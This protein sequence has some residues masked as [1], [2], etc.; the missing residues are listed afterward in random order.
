[1]LQVLSWIWSNTVIAGKDRSGYKRFS[2]SDPASFGLPDSPYL[3]MQPV[4]RVGNAYVLRYIDPMTMEKGTQMFYDG[5]S[6][7][8]FMSAGSPYDGEL[9]GADLQEEQQEAQKIERKKRSQE[10]KLMP[11]TPRV[12]SR[13]VADASAD[14]PADASAIRKLTPLAGDVVMVKGLPD[15]T[16]E[17]ETPSGGLVISGDL[18]KQVMLAPE[19]G[20]ESANKI[21]RDFEKTYGSTEKMRE[22]LPEQYPNLAAYVQ[23]GLAKILDSSKIFA[24]YREGV[25]EEGNP[26]GEAYFKNDVRLYGGVPDEFVREFNVDWRTPNKR[27]NAKTGDEEMLRGY[28]SPQV[29][30]LPDPTAPK[31][32]IET[33]GVPEEVLEEAEQI[34][35]KSMGYKPYP[36]GGVYYNSTDLFRI[37]LG[38]SDGVARTLMHPSVLPGGSSEKRKRRRAAERFIDKI[39]RFC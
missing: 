3:I 12:V 6:V 22:M 19:M 36:D 16:Y 8:A 34:A 37:V 4:E 25:G 26:M 9:V 30:F 5:P 17:V 38:L 31:A 21:Q 1:M 2:I 27:F 10:L 23:M 24:N 15:G 18:F 7:S 20:R 32:D 13:D 11:L 28:Y 39:C 29:V 33:A 14:N 35:K